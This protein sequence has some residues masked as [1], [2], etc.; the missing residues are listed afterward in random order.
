[1]MAVATAKRGGMSKLEWRNVLMGLLFISPWLLGF[2]GFTAYPLIS[3]LYYSLTRYDLI[4][5]SI[6][7]GAENYLEIFLEDPLFRTVAWNTLY[8]VGLSVPLG[9]TAAFLMASLLNTD[10]RGRSIFRAI[11]FFPAIIPAFV[12][13][14]VWQ[15]LLNAQYG[16]I[17][18]TLKALDLP[19]IP[20]IANPAYAKPTLI[21]IY[22]WAQGN[23][24]VIFL[25]TL[26]DVPR[27]LYEAATVDGAN[28]W[29]KFWNVTIPMCTPVILFN[30]VVG[31]IYGFQSFTLPWLLTQGGPNFATEFYSIYL[32]RN[33]FI[34]L[35]MGKASALA[36]ILFV[37][38]VL[39][40]VLLFRTSRGWV[41]YSSSED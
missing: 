27:T 13:A 21:L 10:I 8:Y 37:V 7:I 25:A 28:A 38:I 6:F 14:M 40:T 3:S 12:T 9:V 18:G 35:R 36:W 15:F 19:I 30:L 33:A 16:A 1:M 23:A 31:F 17:N 2:L 4:R 41:F 34:Y 29:D 39:F 32:Y 24:I 26:Q 22:L 20:F 5:P 11:F